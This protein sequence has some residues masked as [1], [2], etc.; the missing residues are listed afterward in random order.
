MKPLE[1][2]HPDGFLVS[3][4]LAGNNLHGNRNSL[5]WPDTLLPMSATVPDSS[6]EI[7]VRLE[8]EN[9]HY[10][11][12]E[13]EPMWLSCCPPRI[14]Y[15]GISI[16]SDFVPDD[17]I[18]FWSE[19]E[20]CGFLELGR[21]GP[22]LRQDRKKKVEFDIKTFLFNMEP[23]SWC[24]GVKNRIFGS[25]QLIDITDDA[26]GEPHKDAKA[27][28]AIY[29]N[30]VGHNKNLQENVHPREKCDQS[31]YYYIHISQPMRKGETVELLVDYK[32]VYEK[33]RERK[34]YGAANLRGDIKGDDH[35]PSKIAR[36]FEE[37]RALKEMVSSFGVVE[38]FHTLEFLTDRILDPVSKA[39]AWLEGPTDGPSP[40]PLQMIARMRLHWSARYFQDRVTLLRSQE[41]TLD[42]SA[43]GLSAAKSLLEQCAKWAR[44]LEW[45]GLER[46]ASFR[47]PKDEYRSLFDGELNEEILYQVS[48]QIPMP[49]DST[50]WC[51]V[52][53]DLT[54]ELCNAALEWPK[55]QTHGRPHEQISWVRRNRCTACEIVSQM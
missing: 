41:K 34:G 1:I 3:I 6:K 33:N 49:L 9:L 28:P 55:K 48:E 2:T 44:G 5:Y 50:I 46:K 14:G 15:L 23:S 29:V 27:L 32:D 12:D 7:T 26:T 40:T 45:D 38:L 21:Y 11:S 17:S 47:F 39:T 42:N 36:N 18:V 19:K 4:T 16:E 35:E 20:G 43:L 53:R 54:K 8:G 13:E 31:V 10:D 22:A 52:A 30:E 37:R 25:D 24:F 51:K